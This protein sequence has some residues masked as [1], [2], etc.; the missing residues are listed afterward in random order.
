MNRIRKPEGGKQK[1]AKEEKTDAFLGTHP[2]LFAREKERPSVVGLAGF[3]DF[4]LRAFRR[5]PCE[6]KLFDVRREVCSV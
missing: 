6:G 3:Q 4:R 1:K 2:F 5:M